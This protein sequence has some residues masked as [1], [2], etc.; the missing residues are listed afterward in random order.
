MTSGR[1]VSSLARLPVF[2]SSFGEWFLIA[3]LILLATIVVLQ[4]T[5][6]AVIVTQKTKELWAWVAAAICAVLIL[7]S[8]IGRDAGWRR[9]QLA[10]GTVSNSY[11]EPRR[12]WLIDG[13]AIAGGVAGGLW[14]GA[15]TWG[16]LWRGML[17][18]TTN[19]GLLS[20]EMGVVVG[21]LS[22]GLV[23]AVLGLFVGNL[24][25]RFHRRRRLRTRR[26]EPLSTLV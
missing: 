23:G 12:R 3:V 26:H 11:Y 8:G 19:R 2:P 15:S 21:V 16:V 1:R 9:E 13:G 24:W 10:L 7:R 18:G 17:R 6:H 4:D 22:G 5:R 14:W 25:E 20:F